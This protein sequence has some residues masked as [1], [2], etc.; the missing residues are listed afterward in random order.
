MSR[1]PSELFI[2]D[3]APDKGIESVTVGVKQEHAP[4]S[5]VRDSDPRERRLELLEDRGLGNRSISVLPPKNN[6]RGL[7]LTPSTKS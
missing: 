4:G 2:G 3:L 5:A 1:H 7:R 6:V